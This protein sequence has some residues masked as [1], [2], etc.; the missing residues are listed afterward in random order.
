MYFT[1]FPKIKYE[2][3]INNKRVVKTVK[4]ITIN[5]RIQK[6]ILANYTLYDEYDMKDGDTP[7]MISYKLYDTAIYHWVVM[8]CNLKFDWRKDFPLPV[9]EFEEYLKDKY[10]TDVNNL[11]NQIHHYEDER[12]FIINEIPDGF[13]ELDLPIPVPIPITVYN[14]ES[15]LNDDKRRIKVISKDNLN[16][17]IG[18]FKDLIK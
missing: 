16:V 1:R 18:N 13:G 12:G 3:L 6:E 4:D 17:I 11:Y 2:F 5:V 10:S 14:Y 15:K 9:Y 8:L 7:E